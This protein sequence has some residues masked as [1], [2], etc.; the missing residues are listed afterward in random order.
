[1]NPTRERILDTAEICFAQRGFDG[2]SLREITRLA[3]VNLGAVN[4]HFGSKSALFDEVLRR[5]FEPMN[6]RRMELLDQLIAREAPSAPPL[7]DMLE[8]YLRPPAEAFA[9]PARATLLT[10][11]LRG[12]MS[13][14]TT[15]VAGLK[16]ARSDSYFMGDCP[17]SP[18][19]SSAS[20]ISSCSSGSTGSALEPA[21]T[22]KLPLTT[23]V[24]A[25]RASKSKFGTAS[26]RKGV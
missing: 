16:G 14:S 11:M 9:S 4:Y 7:E 22:S 25:S 19:Y 26:A 17:G 6:Q 21:P 13:V 1:M 8:A 15:S 5:R 23:T 24:T 10:V 3:G 18:Q 20:T 2:S 12:T